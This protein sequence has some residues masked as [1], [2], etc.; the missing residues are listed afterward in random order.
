LICLY[1]LL[2]LTILIEEVGL[3]IKGLPILGI[4]FQGPVY[5]GESQVP[6]PLLIMDKPSNFI[7]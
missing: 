2:A 4:D 7:S 3:Q 5:V 1:G 6:L